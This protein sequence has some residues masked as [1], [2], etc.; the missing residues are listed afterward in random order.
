MSKWQRLL[1]DA[2][3]VEEDGHKAY[4]VTINTR[5]DTLSLKVKSVTAMLRDSHEVDCVESGLSTM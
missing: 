1:D 3:N 2:M 5:F 4:W